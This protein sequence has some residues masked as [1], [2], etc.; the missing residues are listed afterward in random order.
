MIIVLHLLTQTLQCNS[1]EQQL[2]GA[3]LVGRSAGCCTEQF[4]PTK[5]V[6]KKWKLCH[7][8]IISILMPIQLYHIDTLGTRQIEKN[9]LSHLLRII[10]FIH[11][12]A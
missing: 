7:I 10:R 8:F 5:H 2:H 12:S 6:T 4:T 1:A 3:L 11:K 9:L